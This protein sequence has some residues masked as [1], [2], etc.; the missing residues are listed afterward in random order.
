MVALDGWERE[1]L[2]TA[3]RLVH[4]CATVRSWWQRSSL[5]RRTIIL[6]LYEHYCL[7][8]GLLQYISD[9]HDD[10]GID[11]PWFTWTNTNLRAAGLDA[12]PQAADARISSTAPPV[13]RTQASI[14]HQQHRPTEGDHNCYGRDPLAQFKTQ[15]ES[16]QEST[17][18]R[19][20]RMLPSLSI[21]R[22]RLVNDFCSLCLTT[23]MHIQYEIVPNTR[24]VHGFFLS[25]PP[26][27]QH[28]QQDQVQDELR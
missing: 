23:G 2:L 13:A 27:S 22:P 26:C 3:R 12:D 8:Q 14:L 17:I 16:I 25:I 4:T 11:T 24:P 18:F 1:L 9:Q 21:M 6:L 7:H 28:A 10:C 19:C 20:S 5:D 15:H